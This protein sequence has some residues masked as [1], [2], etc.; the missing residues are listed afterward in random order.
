[1]QARPA[2]LAARRAYLFRGGPNPIKPRRDQR[3]LLRARQIGHVA[4][5]DQGILKIG[6]D[7]REIIGVENNQGRKI[8]HR[9]L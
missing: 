6:R 2:T 7:H 5:P 9:Y 4:D 3:E 8:G 1:M